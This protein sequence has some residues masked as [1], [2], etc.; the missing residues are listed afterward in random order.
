AEVDDHPVLPG[1]GEQVVDPEHLIEVE[2]Q[3]ADLDQTVHGRGLRA[4]GEDMHPTR[5]LWPDSNRRGAGDPRGA[6]GRWRGPH[7][8]GPT[9]LTGRAASPKLRTIRALGTRPG[10]GP[11]RCEGLP[12]ADPSAGCSPSPSSPR[13]RPMAPRPPR[14]R[15]RTTSGN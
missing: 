14:I 11:D 3:G 5:D 10:H 12:C 2:E 6:S 7:R 1:P 13:R 15:E 9:G 8:S 4:R